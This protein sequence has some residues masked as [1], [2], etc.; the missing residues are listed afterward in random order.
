MADTP[1]T[2]E[3]ADRQRCGERT[4]A[5]TP[6]RN[7][8]VE[9]GRCRIHARRA[10]DEA[11]D[12]AGTAAAGEA[13]RAG[14]ARTGSAR[15]GSARAGG[16][17][18]SGAGSSG[19]RSG[20]A[21][22]NG[23]GPRRKAP[24]L[25]DFATG[26]VP[27]RAGFRT[28]GFEG[29]AAAPRRPTPGTGSAR[30]PAGADGHG[31]P[32]DVLDALA[33][34]LG[35]DLADHLSGI[36]GFLR[37]RFTG[38]YEIDDFGLDPD[39]LVNVMRPL[40][41][42]LY[43]TWWRVSSRDREHIPEGGGLLVANHAGTLPFDGIMLNYDVYDATG[44]FLREL[45]ANLVFET[46]FVGHFARK[47]GAVRASQADADA[48]L[49]RG[50]LAGVFPEGFKGLGKPFSQRYQLER[51]GRG[52]FVATALR[53]KVPIVPVAIVGSEEIYPML[54]DA[55]MVA[56]A[57]GLPYFPIVAQMFTL[58][59]LGPLGLLP[60]PSKW[61][62]TYGEPIET[63]HLGPAAAEDPMVVFDLADRV[64]DTIQGMLTKV[65]MGRQSVFF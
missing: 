52:G 49:E 43:D 36:G 16:A 30:G 15:P 1:D 47:S 24:T 3:A 39:L 60:L 51:F 25:G 21:G 23:A 48:V 18:T 27:D 9:D 37:R 6:C 58:P 10:A 32:R 55:R 38:E 64:R 12:G 65:V 11:P 46:P 20:G 4:R 56:R 35:D 33:D 8:A 53:A 7:W 42:P 29:S 44:R 34:V 54:F 40:M 17:R 62:I 59:V 26:P 28:A 13:P 5:G 50:D 57:L 31:E 61:S 41:R 19:A 14:G 45:G 2:P 63:A 22:S